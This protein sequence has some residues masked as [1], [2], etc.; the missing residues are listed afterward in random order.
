MFTLW[1]APTKINICFGF[2]KIK[3][4]NNAALNPIAEIKLINKYNLY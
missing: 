1:S 3:I 4:I 2:R